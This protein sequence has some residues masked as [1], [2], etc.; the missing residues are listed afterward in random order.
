M[1]KKKDDSQDALLM[2]QFDEMKTKHP[3]AILLFRRND[4]Y[5]IFRQDAQNAKEVLG[6]DPVQ[7]K[8]G[9][10]KTD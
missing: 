10:V 2:R 6:L 9:G 3:D 1:A 5:E 7:K 8:I 4:S